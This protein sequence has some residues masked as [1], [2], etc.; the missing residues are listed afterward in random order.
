MRYENTGVENV[1]PSHVVAELR[2]NSSLRCLFLI[3]LAKKS[4]QLWILLKHI[5]LLLAFLGHFQIRSVT[6]I[7]GRF[8]Y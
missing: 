8:P 7:V 4:A 1:Q 2:G 5:S 3:R 6:F